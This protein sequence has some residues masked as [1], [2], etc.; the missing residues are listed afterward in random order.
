MRVKYRTGVRAVYCD[1]ISV[2][3]D[4][5][6]VYQLPATRGRIQ[7]APSVMDYTLLNPEVRVYLEC[8]PDD[9]I[10]VRRSA[11][12]P[13]EYTNLRYGNYTLH[14][15]IVDGRSGSTKLHSAG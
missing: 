3:P 9:G 2:Y 5:D 1:D 12:T 4:A 11:L 7:I 8:G 10:T 15:Q 6:G 14:I 13:L